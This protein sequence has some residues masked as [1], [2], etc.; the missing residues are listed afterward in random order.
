MKEPK[1]VYCG[2]IYSSFVLK[3]GLSLIQR[4]RAVGDSLQRNATKLVALGIPYMYGQQ[5]FQMKTCSDRFHQINL[6]GQGL[7]WKKMLLAM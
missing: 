3:R 1:N 6:P 7:V 5:A 4:L 2:I